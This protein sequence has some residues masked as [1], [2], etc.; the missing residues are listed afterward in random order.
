MQSWKYVTVGVEDMEVAL[1][2]WVKEF[3]FEIVADQAGED[4]ALA[5]LWGLGSSN[6]IVRQTIVGTPG[7]DFGLIHF[8]QFSDPEP[9]VRLGAE[10]FD[11]LPKNL[12]VHAKD[13]PLRF[14]ELKNKGRSFR[15]DKYSEVTSPSG[16]TFREIH[17]RGHDETNI[18]LLEVIGEDHHY[19]EN[20]Y[21]G[22]GPVIIIVP[23]AVAEQAFFIRILGLDV[24]SENLLNGPE[25]ERMV[26][27]PKGSGLDVRVLGNEQQHFGRIEIVD[28]Q[29]VDGENR[30]P[31][32][33]PP[34]LGTLHVHYKIE[35]LGA[36]KSRL[37]ANDIPF[38]EHNDVTS[39][40]GG[41]PL[42]TFVSPAGLRIE[43]QQ[44]Q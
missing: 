10:V 37:A 33:K 20:G 17:M 13:L 43:A 8:V 5:A 18:V 24:L 31:R 14:S 23:D 19:T 28:Y 21:A 35:D 6:R 38:D 29:G 2:L 3:G 34:A 44:S 7:E 1:D 42:L 11:L 4:P 9:P 39:M 32:A 15:S 12:D 25:V 22:V 30:Y 36:L 26:G 16:T 41:G 40:L 27:L